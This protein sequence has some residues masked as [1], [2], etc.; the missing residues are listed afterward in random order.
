M[1]SIRISRR[2][3]ITVACT[4]TLLAAPTGAMAL[5]TH[6]A[7]TSTVNS[8]GFLVAT[9]VCGANERVVSG[10]YNT[11]DT[12]QAGAAVVSHAVNG[13]SWRVRFFTF[14]TPES[15][16]TYAYCAPTDQF[17]ISGHE[18]E[19]T[20]QPQP[21]NNV[22]T[23]SCSS[24][25]TLVSGGYALL[26]TQS[27]VEE[28]PTYRDHAAGGTDWTVMSVFKGIPGQLAAFAYCSPGVTVKVRSAS[29]SIGPDVTA[30]T[31][32]SATASCQAGETLLAG[33]YTT[34]PTPDWSNLNGPDFFYS[35]S[36]RSGQR[37][38]TASATNY[39]DPAGT[40]KV[41]AYCM[42]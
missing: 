28:S 20:A 31:S 26:T 37:S 25:E 11:T 23:A 1:T 24:S 10:G 5:T 21:T 38:W 41:L 14:T 34:K 30:P 2:I 29:T 13:D 16:T 32:G 12:S 33:G 39:S 4:A 17:S 36:Y 19:V 15:L 7:T 22:A 35:G 3:A 8:K 18:N 42:P 6:S 9:A 40:L 27:N